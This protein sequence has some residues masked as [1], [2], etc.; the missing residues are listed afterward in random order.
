GER[1]VDAV[2]TRFFLGKN[3]FRNDRTARMSR[4]VLEVECSRLSDVVRSGMN[5]SN[6]LWELLEENLLDRVFVVGTSLRLVK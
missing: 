6:K 3:K 2:G 4:D 5:L 1:S